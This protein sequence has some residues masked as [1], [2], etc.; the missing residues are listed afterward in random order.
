MD[1]FILVDEIM[2]FTQKDLIPEDIMILD[3][4]FALYVWI[5]KLSNREDQRLSIKMALEYLQAGEYTFINK[6]KIRDHFR[7]F[8]SFW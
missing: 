3:T 1:F 5:G 7:N 8:R 4:N 2:Y 6:C